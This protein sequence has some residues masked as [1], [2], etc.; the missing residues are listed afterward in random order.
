MTEMT[1]VTVVALSYGTIILLLGSRS[2][3]H[4]QLL[5]LS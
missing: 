5:V 3:K 2:N 1:H 4:F